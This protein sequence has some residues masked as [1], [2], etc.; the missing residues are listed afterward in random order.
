MFVFTSARRGPAA[1]L[2]GSPGER[3]R[4]PSG[5]SGGYRSHSRSLAPCADPGCASG[6]LC[7]L[8]M[9]ARDTVEQLSLLISAPHCLTRQPWAC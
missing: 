8:Q 6:T 2:C 5:R 4:W 3:C 1:A 7:P 9:T